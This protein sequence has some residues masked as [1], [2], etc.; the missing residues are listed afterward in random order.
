MIVDLSAPRSAS[1]NDCIS[2]DLCSL[3][4]SSVEQ[5]ARLVKATG[6]GALMVKL[7][8]SSAYR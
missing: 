2:K 7:D 8:L 1:V 3:L 6:L 4:Y 5:A